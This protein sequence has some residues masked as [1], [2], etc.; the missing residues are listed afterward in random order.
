VNIYE[1]IGGMFVVFFT[2]VGIYVTGRLVIEGI[3]RTAGRLD[4]G[5]VTEDAAVR[6][7]LAVKDQLR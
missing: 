7:F 6:D 3:R 5:A 2:C 1:A 4:I